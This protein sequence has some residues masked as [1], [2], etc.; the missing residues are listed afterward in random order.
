MPFGL[1]T[2]SYR[3]D[4]GWVRAA[5]TLGSLSAGCELTHTVQCVLNAEEELVLGPPVTD[6]RVHL[7]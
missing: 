3:V 2:P 7:L 1:T 4:Q 5:Q 6:C